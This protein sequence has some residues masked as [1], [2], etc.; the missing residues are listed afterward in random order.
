MS[1]TKAGLLEIAHNE[2]NTTQH[3]AKLGKSRW[4]VDR[5]RDD[6]SASATAGGAEQDHEATQSQD[7]S[8]APNE[9]DVLPRRPAR[10]TRGGRGAGN[11]SHDTD[12]AAAVHP[13]PGGGG[14]LH[15][16]HKL[17]RTKPARTANPVRYPGQHVFVLID[18]RAVLQSHCVASRRSTSSLTNH[19]AW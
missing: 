8:Q 10:R 7:T 14:A 1:P 6:G 15:E 3:L 9:L 19:L 2:R 5:N 4:L 18:A 12:G 11:G 13:H 17:Y 16:P